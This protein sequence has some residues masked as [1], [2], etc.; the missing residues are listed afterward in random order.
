MVRKEKN[1][2]KKLRKTE[3]MMQKWCKKE[4]EFSEQNPDDNVSYDN[5]NSNI[6]KFS[7]KR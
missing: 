4:K 6:K 1:K 3:K 2:E 5:E 7:N